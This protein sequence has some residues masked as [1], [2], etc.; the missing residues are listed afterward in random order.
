MKV[1]VDEAKCIGCGTCEGF[2]SECFKIVDGVAVVQKEECTDCD[3]NQ[4]VDSC[5]VGA[6]STEE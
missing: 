4:A 2:C 6:I 5:P 3:V 1:K